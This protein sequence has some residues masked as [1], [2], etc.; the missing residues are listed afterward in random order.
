MSFRNRWLI[1]N[2]VILSDAEGKI[3]LEEVRLANQEI[4]TMIREGH[5]ASQQKTHLVIK[6]HPQVYLPNPLEIRPS[7][8]YLNEP[9]LGYVVIGGTHNNPI[10]HFAAGVLSRFSNKSLVLESTV[11][12]AIGLLQSK[13]PTLPKLL[14]AYKELR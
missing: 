1:P 9:S 14:E 10:I 7:V 6:V 3:T 4:T 13:D 11:E 12:R 5:H 8:T 2:R